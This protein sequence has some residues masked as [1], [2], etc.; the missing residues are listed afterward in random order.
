MDKKMLLAI[1]L[2]LAVLFVF[3][4]FVTPPAVQTQENAAR[5]E[6]SSAE[7]GAKS[8]VAPPKAVFTGESGRPAM[9]LDETD[10]VM[11]TD[12]FAITF[13]DAGGAIKKWRLLEYEKNSDEQEELLLQEDSPDRRPFAMR[14]NVLEGLETKICKVNRGENFLEF[15]VEEPKNIQISK[16]FMFYNSKDY[17]ELEINTKNI[18]AAS[19]DI[20]YTMT[21]PSGMVETGEVKGRSFLEVNIKSGDE[22]LRKTAAKNGWTESGDIGWIAEKNR[23]FATILKPMDGVSSA[24]AQGDKKE[25]LTTAVTSKKKTLSP[26]ESYTD[27]YLMYAGPM[28]QIRTSAFGYEFEA[29]INYGWFGGISKILLLILRFFYKW[30]HNW[31]VAIILLTML[32][33]A[34]AFPLTKKS[35]VSMHR[36]KNVQPHIQKLKDL[37]K[38]NP[39]KLNKEMME[40]YKKYN[41]NPFGGCLPMLLQI[42]I[43]IALYQ[44]LIKAVELKGASFLWIKDLATPDAVGLPFSLPVIGAHINIL[45]ILMVGMMFFQQKIQGAAAATTPEQESQQKMMLIMMPVFFGFLFYN[46]PS[47]LVLYWL[48]NTVLMTGEQLFLKKTL[49]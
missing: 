29:V 26:G 43:F 27:A 5:E 46:M 31:G 2:S 14:S 10:I 41:V 44:G 39:Q 6:Q 25:G 4:K 49:S 18:S 47:G 45:P 33:N 12:K 32:V 16:K 19:K 24:Q 30:T 21:G 42:P 38:D 23:Y 22:I 37:H 34:V 36:M 40:L 20:E 9:P 13:S 11:N 3:Q 17:I 35:F 7:P 28:D 48:T 8:E 1:S 15:I